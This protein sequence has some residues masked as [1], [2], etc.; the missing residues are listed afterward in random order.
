MHASSRK[1][2]D[3]L[4]A[5]TRTSVAA[6]SSTAVSAET[7][8]LSSSTTRA[9]ASGGSADAKGVLILDASYSMVEEDA[10][11]PRIDAA[12]KATR[13]LVDFLPDTAQR[14]LIAYGAQESNAPDNREKGCKD[15]QRL[16]PIGKVDKQKFGAAIDGLTPKGYT[17][18]GNALRKAR[19][20]HSLPG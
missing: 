4:F 11:G 15:I 14:G 3:W 8:T 19:H 7:K 1:T 2:G 10:E 16:V 9:S 13:E 18:M 20:Q 12:K 6:E 5:I 17:P